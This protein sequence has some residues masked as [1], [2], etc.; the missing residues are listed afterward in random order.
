VDTPVVVDA[1]LIP[2]A[3]AIPFSLS[4]TESGM[5]RTLNWSRVMIFPVRSDIIFT[6]PVRLPVGN[7]TTQSSVRA[8]IEL[9]VSGTVL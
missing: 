3:T 5:G 8:F 1:V 9:S 7:I 4:I 2:S 6:E